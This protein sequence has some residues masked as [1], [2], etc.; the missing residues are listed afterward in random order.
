M[1]MLCLRRISDPTAAPMGVAHSD[2]EQKLLDYMTKHS[3]APTFV[4]V[5]GTKVFRVFAPGSGLEDFMP[6]TP[7]SED[8]GVK[9][10]DS[11]DQTVKAILDSMRP[12][13]EQNVVEAR[14]KMYKNTIPVF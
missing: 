5:N 7:G 13:V 12:Q 6:P 4:E 3:S 11:V 9:K 1:Y 2:S 8:E 10:L 14:Q